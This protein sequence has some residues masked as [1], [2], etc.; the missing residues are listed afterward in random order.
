MLWAI[1]MLQETDELKGKIDE[2]TQQFNNEK[3]TTDMLNTSV[4]EVS[5][6]NNCFK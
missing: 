1:S 4:S 6:S 3:E 5:T 2:L